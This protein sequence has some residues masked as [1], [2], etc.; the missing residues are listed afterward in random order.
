[1]NDLFLEIIRSPDS[2]RLASIPVVMAGIG[3]L[4]ARIVITLTFRPLAFVGFRPL[5]L[6]WRGRVPARADRLA[7][8]L[9][10]RALPGPGALSELFREMEPEKV[11]GHIAQTINLDLDEYVD[12]AM[13][14]HDEVLWENV[15]IIA[16]NRIY[17]RARRQTPEVMDNI[18][19]DLSENIEE[20]VDAREMVVRAMVADRSLPGRVLLAVGGREL[21]ALARRGAWAGLFAGLLLM[22]VWHPQVWSWLPPLAVAALGAVV[23]WITLTPLCRP[24]EPL[25]IGPYCLQGVF[26]RRRDELADGFATLLTEEVLNLRSIMTEALSG[27]QAHRTRAIVKRHLRPLLESS[28][29]RTAIQLSMGAEGYANLKH[30]VTARVV[31]MTLIAISEPRFTRERSGIIRQMFRKRLTELSNAEFHELLRPAFM[32]DKWILVLLGALLGGI[33]GWLQLM[34]MLAI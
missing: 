11:A 28:V 5:R 22:F 16:K 17:A 21:S 24:V 15:P 32:E 26:M 7:S 25:W 10:E 34:V 2:W 9:A 20:L 27:A 8:L 18:L 12:L 3:W 1:M 29:V 19:D 23:G 31:E 13:G 6:G 33:A 4:I 30:R 14:E